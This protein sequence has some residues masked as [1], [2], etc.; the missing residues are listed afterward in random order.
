VTGMPVLYQR[1]LIRQGLMPNQAMIAIIATPRISIANTSFCPEPA[2]AA[3]GG[4]SIYFDMAS[5]I[6]RAVSGR[7]EGSLDRQRITSFVTPAGTADPDSGG[8]SSPV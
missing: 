8:G 4:T 1:F 6:S 3:G 7:F 5:S 2:A